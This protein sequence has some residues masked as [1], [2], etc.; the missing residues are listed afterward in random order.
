VLA[1]ARG[2][3]GEIRVEESA[4]MRR[5]TIDE[6]VVT[7]VPTGNGAAPPAP[8]PLAGLVHAL[9]PGARSALV[10]GLGG[11]SACRRRTT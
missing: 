6:A 5:L 9:R 10:I 2:E 1:S 11:G 3:H 7:E 8:D 4:G